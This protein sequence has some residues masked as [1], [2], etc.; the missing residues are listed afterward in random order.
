MS[1]ASGPDEIRP[2]TLD[3]PRG[4]TPL[5][6]GVE[7]SSPVFSA[8]VCDG[9]RLLSSLKSEDPARRSDGLAE[10]IQEAIRAAGLTLAELDG[11]AVSIGPGSFTGLRVGV[12]TVKTLAW[13][14]KK[15]I[16]PV[17]TLEVIASNLA[18]SSSPIGV[19]LDARKG[20]VYSACFEPNGADPLKRLSPDRLLPPEEALA[21]IP[22]EAILAG[23]GLRRYRE[24]VSSFPKWRLAPE[25]DWIP[26]AEILCRIA[27]SRWPDGVLDDPHRLVPQYLYSK[28]SDITGW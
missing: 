11:F 17:S 13:A 16:L 25:P 20:K 21:E 27:S 2:G 18:R 1:D 22:P 12:T 5:L 8:A 15:K 23:D 9:E 10:M 14:L 4:L 26:S 3:P 7:T 6:L 19:F 24:L 28:E